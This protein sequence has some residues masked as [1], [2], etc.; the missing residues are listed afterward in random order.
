MR[1]MM[2]IKPYFIIM[3]RNP[4]GPGNGPGNEQ[5]DGTTI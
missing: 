3:L 5:C 1:K 4:G 2:K